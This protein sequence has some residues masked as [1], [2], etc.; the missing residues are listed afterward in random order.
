M[1]HFILYFILLNGHLC[2]FFRPEG[3]RQ[4]I[5]LKECLPSVSYLC[6][7]LWQTC[8]MRH[9]WQSPDIQTRLQLWLLCPRSTD[10]NYCHADCSRWQT[11]H[12]HY[13]PETG[14][15]G[16]IFITIYIWL[17]K[18][19]CHFGHEDHRIWHLSQWLS[20]FNHTFNFLSLHSMAAL[21][22]SVLIQLITTSYKTP[23][24]ITWLTSFDNIKEAFSP[25]GL[26]GQ[27]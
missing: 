18:Q 24:P 22:M 11:L 9:R 10:V 13:D 7:T 4:I 1:N 20:I 8:C 15:T 14:K 23:L 6:L 27:M 19:T 26:M 25:D 16:V 3:H 5:L 21:E 17:T 12:D 2:Y